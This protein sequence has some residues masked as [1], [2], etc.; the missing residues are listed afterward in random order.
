MPEGYKG[1]IVEKTLDLFPGIIG[2]QP[3]DPDKAVH[4]LFEVITGEGSG[5]KLRGK[6]LRLLLGMDAV[7]RI[8]KKA[9]TVL[10]DV[11][12]ARRLEGEASTAFGK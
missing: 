3:G 8:D 12:E 5:G 2:K 7:D 6:V 11:A 10:A 4:R 1:S 9:R